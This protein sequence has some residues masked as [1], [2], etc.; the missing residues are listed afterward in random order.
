MSKYSD[1]ILLVISLIIWVLITYFSK[2]YQFV[3]YIAILFFAGGFITL[4]LIPYERISQKHICKDKGSLAAT[5]FTF[6]AI[7]YCISLW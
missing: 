5:F 4:L 6:A 3:Y 7:F 2:K 1:Y